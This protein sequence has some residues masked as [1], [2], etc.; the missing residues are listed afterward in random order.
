MFRPSPL[1]LLLCFGAVFP[2]SCSNDDNGDSDSADSGAGTG[3]GGISIG[4]GDGDG[5]GDGTAAEY[6]EE[7]RGLG[8]CGSDAVTATREPVNILLV[9]DKSGSMI[10]KADPDSTSTLWEATTTALEVALLS[11]NRNVHFGLQTYPKNVGLDCYP[12]CCAMPEDEEEGVTVPV[13]A[14]D[15]HREAILT[16]LNRTSPGG[17]TPTAD[18]LAKAF[19]YYSTG[20]GRDL[21]GDRFVLLATDGGPN[22]NEGLE[23]DV[24]ECTLNID[25]QCELPNDGNCCESNTEGCLDDNGTLDQIKLLRGIGVDTF[26]IGLSG[27]EEYAVQLDSFAVAGGRARTGADE[28]YYKVGAEGSS[29]GLRKVLNKITRDLVQS[30]DIQLSESP[31]DPNKLNVAVDCDVI[32][33]GDDPGDE[34]EGGNG[35]DPADTTDFW[36]LDTNTSPPTVRIRGDICDKIESEGVER[37][38]IVRGCPTVR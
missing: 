34:G 38:D 17:G 35:G 28:D 36:D 12:D 32:P 30:C 6:C 3:G 20:S 1:W 29:D 24:D 25:D 21:E 27:S 5:D 33:R 8:A 23:C 31:Q 19:S 15:D 2:I 22:C 16:Q 10:C 9:C 11:T 13:A 7:F 18:A 26:V 37:V 4:D 14:G